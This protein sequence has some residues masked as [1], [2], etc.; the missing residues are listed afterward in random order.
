MTYV[1]KTDWKYDETVTE[2]DF[3]RI[4]RRVA[5]SAIAIL[6]TTEPTDPDLNTFWFE[7]VGDDY[8][9]GDGLIIENAALDGSEP[10]WLDEE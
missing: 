8:E 10:I 6:S 9:P 7:E 4:E 2:T 5:D 3:N 1:S